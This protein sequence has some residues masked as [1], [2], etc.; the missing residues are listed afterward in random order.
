[1]RQHVSFDTLDARW[2]LTQNQLINQLH[3]SNDFGSCHGTCRSPEIKMIGITTQAV[4]CSMY[5]GAR[6][7][8][9]HSSRSMVF[10][11]NKMVHTLYSNMY[12]ITII[13]MKGMPN[14]SPCF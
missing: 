9:A 6:M 10:C 1:M 2:L 8:S 12:G 13:A 14:I 7:L 3:P 5:Q 4:S 11:S